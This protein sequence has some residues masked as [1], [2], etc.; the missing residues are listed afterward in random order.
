MKDIGVEQL[1]SGM[2]HA[3]ELFQKQVG[4]RRLSRAE[5]AR[6]LRLLRPTLDYTGFERVD[7]VVEAVVERL[8]VKHQVFSELEQHVGADCVLATNTSSI[9]IDRIAEG[10]ARP[11]RLVGMHFFNPV[12]KMPLVEV[13]RGSATSDRAAASVADFARRLGKIPV[14]VRVGPGFLVNRLLGFNL[15]EAMWLLD[16]GYPIEEVDREVTDWGLPMGP[17]TLTDEVGIDVAVEVARILGAAYP[18]RLTF[19]EWFERLPEGGRLGALP[20]PI[21]LDSH[22][23][24]EARIALSELRYRSLVEATTSVVRG[25]N[26][27]VLMLCER[28]SGQESTV[29]FEIIGTQLLNARMTAQA[30]D[31]LADL[32]ARSVITTLQ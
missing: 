29:D 17:F 9:S 18:G 8:P 20:R 7:L 21:V 26:A 19:P 6:K 11:E 27:T 13:I 28:K 10:V 25:A 14:V 2:R 32:R 3:S 5:A 4:R 16:E 22:K 1:A 15:A 31:Y 24:A 30:V 23:K 12:H